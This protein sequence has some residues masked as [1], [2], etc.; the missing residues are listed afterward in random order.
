M[1]GLHDAKERRLRER[2]VL[3]RDFQEEIV[4]YARESGY[5]YTGADVFSLPRA[6]LKQQ[7]LDRFDIVC[8]E[9]RD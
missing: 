5:R 8:D 1:A 9:I 3:E 6:Q 7:Y 4:L 2:G